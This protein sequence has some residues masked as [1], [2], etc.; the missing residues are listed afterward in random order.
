M[1]NLKMDPLAEFLVE[2]NYCDSE[3]AALKILEASSSE[4]QDF[5]ILELFGQERRI[6]KQIDSATD[7]AVE[8]QLRD[9]L[10]NVQS[11]NTKIKRTV[12]KAASMAG[13]R[14]ARSS[15]LKKAGKFVT[16]TVLGSLIPF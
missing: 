9:K 5:I 3:E 7:P 14:I 13:R 6:Q 2:N 4:F 10:R 1:D 11:R 12:S 16:R 8:R 15:T